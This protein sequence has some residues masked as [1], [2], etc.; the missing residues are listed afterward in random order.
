M[1]SI[2]RPL[3]L[4]PNAK[5]TD[6]TGVEVKDADVYFAVTL[7]VD[8]AGWLTELRITDLTLDDPGDAN[9]FPPR[10]DFYPPRLEQVPRP[11]R[12]RFRNWRRGKGLRAIQ[13]RARESLVL[14]YSERSRT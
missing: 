2:T 11:R 10:E 14:N 3:P 12:R 13:A 9:P 4:P 1:G 6:A 8:E 5:V 7:W